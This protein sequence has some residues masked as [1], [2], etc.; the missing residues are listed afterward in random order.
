MTFEPFDVVVVPFPF[1]DRDA[2]VRR[3]ALVVSTKPFNERHGQIVLAMIT[4]ARRSDWPSDVI[5]E[6]W[7][8][9][10]LTVACRVRLKLFTL[11]TALVVRRLGALTR[12]DRD[13]VRRALA[14]HLAVA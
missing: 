1:T 7:A 12:A 3:P 11:D 9:A 6:D 4:T 5:I 2:A 14:R 13:A 8:K 10:G